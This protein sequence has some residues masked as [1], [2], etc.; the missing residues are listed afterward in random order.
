MGDVSEMDAFLASFPATND[1][2]LMLCHEHGAAYQADMSYRVAVP[3]FDKCMEYRG[4]EIA[5]RINICRRTL[6]DAYAGCSRAVLD[7]GVG[8]G[9]FIEARPHTWGYDVDER[10]AAWLRE[11]GKWSDRFEDFWAF[12]FW[13]VIEHLEEPYWDYFRHIRPGAYL[14][15]CLP[16]FTDLCRIRESRHY[17]PG[18]HLMYFTEEG[19]VRWMR[20][21]GFECLERNDFETR[22]GRDSILSFVFRRSS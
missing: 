20:M 22:A 5:L 19:F 14:F 12:T 13:D 15:T 8:S 6:V 11:V 16:I 2:D 18:E 4:E 1:A 10:A 9:E 21:H 17:R 7:V 3:Y